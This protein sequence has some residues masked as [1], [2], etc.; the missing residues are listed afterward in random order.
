MGMNPAA[1]LGETTAVEA[2]AEVAAEAVVVVEVVA[3][4][5]LEKAVEASAKAAE[6]TNGGAAEAVM[7]VDSAAVVVTA[8]ETTVESPD[9]EGAVEVVEEA[10]EAS[11]IMTGVMVASVEATTALEVIS[12]KW[13]SKAKAAKMKSR[14]RSTSPKHPLKMTTSSLDRELVQVCWTLMCVRVE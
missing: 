2:G 9:E 14:K 10:A 6:A 1:V 7:M 3:V 12:P 5:A 13:T 4:E 11:V 8:G